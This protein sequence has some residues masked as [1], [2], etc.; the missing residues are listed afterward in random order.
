MQ[1]TTFLLLILVVA[2]FLVLSLVGTFLPHQMMMSRMMGETYGGMTNVFWPALL[3]SSTALM[4]VV[5]VYMI[6]FPNIKCSSSGEQAEKDQIAP[7]T[8]G[9]PMDIVMRVVKDDE[10]G[11]LEILKKGGGVCFQ[12]D[13]TYKTELSKLKTH[14]I[15][16]RLAERGIIQVKKAAKTNEIRVPSWLR[17]RNS[18]A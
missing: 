3:T 4:A 14:R 7:P 18:E 10:R 6:A 16:A 17:A 1:R 11:V 12:K 5:F 13:I 8:L 2:V 9:D 15:I